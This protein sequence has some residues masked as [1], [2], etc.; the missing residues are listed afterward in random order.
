MLK[1][2][3]RIDLHNHKTGLKDR[4][5]QDNIITNATKLLLPF[6]TTG[7]LDL[8]THLLPLYKRGLGAVML[9]DNTLTENVN[10]VHFPANAH[11][12]GCAGQTQDTGALYGS[13]NVNESSAG[14]TSATNVWDFATHQ[15]NGIIKSV[16]LTKTYAAGGHNCNPFIARETGINVHTPL[17]H[18]GYLTTGQFLWYE[19]NYSYYLKVIDDGGTTH[20][21]E[22]Y[23]CYTPINLLRVADGINAARSEELIDT[24]SFQTTRNTSV[25]SAISMSNSKIYFLWKD[26]YGDDTD[27][28]FSYVTMDIADMVAESITLSSIVSVTC[29]N[30]K[31]Y[32]SESYYGQADC[33]SW[34][35]IAEG[36]AYILGNNAN[37]FYIVDLS[38]TANIIDVPFDGVI[39]GEDSFQYNV[40]NSILTYYNGAIKFYRS[41]YQDTQPFYK[42]YNCIL[43][44]D[45]TLVSDLVYTGNGNPGPGTTRLQGGIESPGLIQGAMQ[46]LN[47]GDGWK[48]ALYL[49]T[50]CDYLG[51]ICNL[52]QAVT[53]TAS[54][55]MK[56]TYTL[57]DITE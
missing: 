40:G 22:I 1:G 20:T 32:P 34:I 44:P 45:G 29:T 27:G 41:V 11:L 33:I 17:N 14:D 51:S 15:A 48:N 37:H 25:F 42:G 53:K 3:V 36:Y 30:A 39:R 35:K 55:S 8:S 28:V 23:K 4:L 47:P 26:A 2:H 57:T 13:L 49:T 24:I 6:Y 12:V 18:A 46:Y 19:N 31:F 10:N 54:T 9:F 7:G 21:A 50:P 16:A 5:E 43:Y 52:S 38:N 56:V